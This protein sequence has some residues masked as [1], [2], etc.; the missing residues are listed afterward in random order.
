MDKAYK[1]KVLRNLYEAIWEYQ[2]SI[3]ESEQDADQALA[4]V[5]FYATKYPGIVAGHISDLIDARKEE[6]L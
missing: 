6:N 3:D 2:N 4:E 5:I 1:E